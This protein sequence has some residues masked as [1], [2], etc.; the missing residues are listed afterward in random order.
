MIQT[1][2]PFA[3]MAI[4]GSTL[5]VAVITI[6]VLAHWPQTTLGWAFLGAISVGVIVRGLCDEPPG[7]E[8]R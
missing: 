2:H 8:R 4:V 5:A 3:L 6:G 7:S 1:K